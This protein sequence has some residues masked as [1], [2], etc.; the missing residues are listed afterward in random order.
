MTKLMKASIM[1]TKRSYPIGSQKWLAQI[2]EEGPARDVRGRSRPTQRYFT[3]DQRGQIIAAEGGNAAIARNVLETMQNTGYVTRFK[4]EPFS[5]TIKEDGLAAT[6]DILFQTQDGESYVV[7]VK[8]SRFLTPEKIEK[9]RQVEIALAGTGLKYLLWTD[10]SPLP[11]ATWRMMRE[12]RRLGFS[13]V[14]PEAINKIVQAVAVAPKTIEQLRSQGMYREPI[15]AAVWHGLV[16][17]NFTESFHDKSVVSNDVS[18]RKFQRYLTATIKTH[19]WWSNLK[20][21]RSTS[22]RKN[23]MVRGATN[24]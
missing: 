11:P 2:Y 24:D 9:C 8:S 14:Q 12:M 10:T 23:E 21:A 16:H 15:L 7:E 3:Y 13:S 6:P 5:L 19:T 18:T 4:L 20:P 22:A 1:G 17:I